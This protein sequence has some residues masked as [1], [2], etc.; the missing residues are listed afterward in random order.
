MK[1]FLLLL[2]FSFSFFN[3]YSATVT[4]VGGATGN[5]STG[6][7]WSG[8]IAPTSVDD[9][10]FNTSTTVTLDVVPTM[11]SL[12]VTS[13]CTVTLASSVSRTVSL[14]S[15]LTSPKGLQIDA[16]SSLIID[17]TN[18]SGTNNLILSLTGAAGVTGLINGNLYFTGSGASSGAAA[19]FDTYTGVVNYADMQV[20]STGYIKFFD[21]TG[22]ASTS[23]TSFTM[24]NGATYEINKNGGSF[25]DGVWN[26]G[27]LAK[28]TG[29][30]NGAPTFNGSTYG[31][32]EWN[33]PS[34]TTTMT[35]GKNISFNNVDIVHTGT[36]SNFR[37]KGGTGLTTYTMTVNGNLTVSSN[38]ILETSGNTTTSGNPGIISV[39]GNITNSGVIRESSTVTGN[40]FQLTGTTNQAIS[41]SGTWSGDEL[42]F[43]MN[44]S[45]GATLNS[46]LVLPYNLTLTSG[47]ITTTSTNLLTM[48]DNTTVSGGSTTSFI[49]GPMKKIGNENFSFPVGKGSI[50]APIGITNVSG[51]LTTDEYTAEY[52]RT[53]PQSVHGSAV[54]SGQDHVSYVEYWTLNSGGGAAAIKKISLQVNATS[55][56]KV[57]AST[58]VSRWDATGPFWTNEGS[59]NSGVIS[60]PPYETGTITSLNNISAFGDFTLITDLSFSANPLPVK[61]ISFNA[62]KINTGL[63]NLSWELGACCSPDAKF[64]VQKSKDGRSFVSFATVPGSGT[65]RF[66][67]LNDNRLDKGITYYRLKMTDADGSVSY[68]KI[69]AIINDE[70]GI[71]ITSLAPNPVHNSTIIILSVAKQT[72]VD[73]KVFDM[74]G[75]VVKQ[76]KSNVAEG[77]SSISINADGLSSG[78]YH[79]LASS[80]DA[81]AFSRF[82]KK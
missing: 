66:Y 20:G 51:E 28:H 25:P 61:L 62:V 55:F 59:T 58:Y 74:S 54:Q 56:C 32:F 36:P 24:Q 11:N 22:N 2:F 9:V 75:R 18:A 19:R 39:K 8:G 44:N 65:N 72:T 77:N 12:L 45:A 76:W 47:K 40:E 49:D 64:E 71:L 81:K 30:T 29:M 7:N 73:F 48:V 4:W 10:I 15:T 43:V 23:S 5:W 80:A 14:S 6:S 13:S 42:T 35:I 17:C 82:I 67:N 68:S 3:I 78:M 53:N 41:G 50:F 16:G 79:I 27:S 63:S 26:S 60:V 37:V 33:C 46:S 1:R 38:A 31:N 57:L 69:V 52:I 70:N 34:Q 21:N